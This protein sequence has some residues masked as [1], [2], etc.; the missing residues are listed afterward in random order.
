MD[1]FRFLVGTPSSYDVIVSMP[2]NPWV[3][4]V[5]NLFSVEAYALA[6]TR[7]RPGGLFAQWVQTYGSEP[8]ILRMILR[9]MMRQF[10][11]ITVFQLQ[12]G[13]DLLLL[14]GERPLTRDDLRRAAERLQANQA[15]ARHLEAIGVTRLETLLALEIIPPAL[16]AE[17]AGNGPEHRLERPLLSRA[18]A[19]AN[20]RN[21]FIDINEFR[22]RSGSF[23]RSLSA[24]LLAAY[25]STPI[26]SAVIDAARESLC[27][28]SV[29]RSV[30][31][32]LCAEALAATAL[33]RASYSWTDRHLGIVHKEELERITRLARGDPA[34]PPAPS[35]ERF[36]DLLKTYWT[37][38]SPLARL[39]E[40]PLREALESCLSTSSADAP[41]RQRCLA[42]KARFGL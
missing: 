1:A 18:A 42:E 31:T 7:L 17:L 33:D 16:A 8:E 20:Y 9:T 37:Y 6:K 26:P 15:A 3:A 10:A 25:V 21:S 40:E 39:P 19:R 34:G 30:E 22:R 4:G 36:K 28:N 2:S 13:G 29:S 5:E 32:F 38:N 27:D 23:H 14:G 24:S 35:S 11:S 41:M 12:R